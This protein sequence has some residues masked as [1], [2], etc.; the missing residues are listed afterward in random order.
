MATRS[1]VSAMVWR[2]QARASRMVTAAW[3]ACRHLIPSY[4]SGAGRAGV[5]RS[6]GCVRAEVVISRVALRSG[7]G[8]GIG[9]SV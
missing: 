6:G 5:T 3:T 9:V 2:S 4:G 7:E 8:N 1:A